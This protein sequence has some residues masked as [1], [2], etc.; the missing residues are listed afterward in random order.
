MVL[1]IFGFGLFFIVGVVL[2]MGDGE[3]C[4]S[5][6]LLDVSSIDFLVV[7]RFSVFGGIDLVLVEIFDLVCFV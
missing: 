2:G 7:I 6:C 1:S 4:F 5:F 3:Y